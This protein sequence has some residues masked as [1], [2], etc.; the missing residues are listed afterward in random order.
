[1]WNLPIKYYNSLVNGELSALISAFF[2]PEHRGSRWRFRWSTTETWCCRWSERASKP[3]EQ[4]LGWCNHDLGNLH[5]MHVHIHIYIYLYIH[6]YIYIYLYIHI[7]I[8]IYICIFIYIYIFIFIY[9]HIYILYYI[10]IYIC[11]YIIHMYIHYTYETWLVWYVIYHSGY[12]NI[13]IG[14][15]YP[16]IRAVRGLNKAWT[17]WFLRRGTERCYFFPG[18]S[19]R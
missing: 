18:R 19:F 10:Y 1:M 4:W 8:Y 9:I 14:A 13:V 3:S 16:H 7:Y 6:R 5:T 12:I 15:P 11:I 2:I 17:I